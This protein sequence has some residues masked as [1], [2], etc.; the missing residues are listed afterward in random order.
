MNREEFEER[1]SIKMADGIPEKE[2]KRQAMAEQK[3]DW[4]ESR[5]R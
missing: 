5:K 1:V 3:A 2:A 4:L